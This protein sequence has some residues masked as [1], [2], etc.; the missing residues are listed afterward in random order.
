MTG[1]PGDIDEA[2]FS[3]TVVPEGTAPAITD[4]TVDGSVVT[5]QLDAFIPTGK[6]TQFTHDCSGTTTCLGYLPADVSNDA[7][8]AP[9]DILWLVDCLNQVRTCEVWQCDVDRSNVCGAPDILR[10]I[11]LLNGADS[12]DP[13]LNVQLPDSPCDGGG[14]SAAT[15]Q[16]EFAD[17]FL[18]LLTEG[19]WSDELSSADIRLIVQGITDWVVAT[20]P[21]EKRSALC[22]QLQDPD[23]TFVNPVISDMM[24]EITAR[25]VE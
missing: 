5:L 2:D 4:V 10:V 1:E 7:T 18:V 24:P 20:L 23:L 6:W 15:S 14:E 11:D 13:W 19:A 21:L 16:Q 8:S 22:K 3:L 9:A 17:A 25:L 12:Y